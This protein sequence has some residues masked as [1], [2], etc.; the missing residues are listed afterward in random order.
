MSIMPEKKPFIIDY[1]K[2]AEEAERK[3]RERR[4]AVPPSRQKKPRS[5]SHYRRPRPNHDGEEI[6]FDNIEWFVHNRPGLVP[7]EWFKENMPWTIKICVVCK[8]EFSTVVYHAG[9][10]K[11]GGIRNSISRS[12]SKKCALIMRGLNRTKDG[13]YL[14]PWPPLDISGLVIEKMP[15]PQINTSGGTRP[16]VIAQLNPVEK[17]I[18]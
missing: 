3:L 12:C 6:D 1:E 14:L 2:V 18:M 17:E 10:L 7:L 15:H 4:L 13:E 8:N 5:R 16:L 9:R 11:S